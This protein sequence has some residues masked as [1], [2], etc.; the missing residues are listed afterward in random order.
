MSLGLSDG[1]WLTFDGRAYDHIVAVCARNGTFNQ[2][3]IFFRENFD[4]AQ[5]LH[6]A[7]LAAHVTGHALI[8]PSATRS[9]AHTDRTDAAVKH[10]TVSGRTAGHT[11]TL[12][13]TLETFTFAHA[14]NSEELRGAR[15]AREHCYVCVMDCIKR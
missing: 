3:E 2:D 5:V 4:H 15:G 14:D 13:D 11:E 10:G 1:F 7:V 6:G 9:L 12:H 8:F